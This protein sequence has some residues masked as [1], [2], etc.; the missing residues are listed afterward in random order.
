MIDA[1]N[2]FFSFVEKTSNRDQR[3]EIVKL[4]I[5]KQLNR[6]FEI[7]RQKKFIKLFTQRD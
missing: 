6:C 4:V 5:V 7:L 3:R 2:L 1:L